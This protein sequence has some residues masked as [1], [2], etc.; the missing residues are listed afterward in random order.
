MTRAHGTTSSTWAAAIT[1]L[2]ATTAEPRRVRTSGLRP[3]QTEGPVTPPRSWLEKTP[4]HDVDTPPRPFHLLDLGAPQSG[5]HAPDHDL[6]E[7]GEARELDHTAPA[8][9]L[10]ARSFLVRTTADIKLRGSERSEG[11]ASFNVLVRRRLPCSFSFE[12]G[13][14]KNLAWVQDVAWVKRRFHSA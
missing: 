4:C 7:Q 2:L 12:H 11:H 6:P 9:T 8:T 5:R 14:L 13:D 3:L 1:S 10:N